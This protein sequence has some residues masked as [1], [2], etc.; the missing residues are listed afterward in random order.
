MFSRAR[1]EDDVTRVLAARR[2]GD[3]A[4]APCKLTPL[5]SPRALARPVKIEEIGGLIDEQA[6]RCGERQTTHA[7]Q[8]RGQLTARWQ[9]PHRTLS[10]EGS[11]APSNH[12]MP[13][14]HGRLT[15]SGP[16]GGHERV[17]V[18]APL[19]GSEAR[20]IMCAWTRLT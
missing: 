5:M 8:H 9:S 20:T 15:S 12:Q 6:D 11:C 14:E 7:V 17:A 10:N 13:V 18:V 2:Q 4:P 1:T 19:D 16:V 3:A